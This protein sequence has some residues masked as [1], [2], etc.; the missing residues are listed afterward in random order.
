MKYINNGKDL[1]V[2]LEGR[3]DTN[4]AAETEKA[5]IAALE[6]YPESVPEFD[7]SS[8]EYISSAG[9]RVMMKM[10]RRFGTKLKAVNA[11]PE[12]YDI[13][14]VTGFTE[15]MNVE[16]RLRE[17]SVDGCEVIGTGFYGTVYRIDPETIVKV[18]Q[19]PECLPI[20]QNERKLAKLAFVKGVPTAISYDI[21][22]VGDSYGTVFELLNAQ[23]FN[24][25]L[26][27]EPENFDD[28]M[29]KYVDFLKVV[30][31]AEMDPGTLPFARDVFLRYADELR[32]CL[33]D[34]QC[35]RLKELFGALPD[36]LHMVHGDYQM[37]NVMMV[38]DEPMLIDMDTLS[39]GQ[40]IFDL[41]ALYVTYVAF[42]ED[43]PDNFMNF[44]GI[45][46]EL[47]KRIWQGILENYFDTKDK[48][49]LADINDKIQLIASMRFLYILNG[50]D[51]RNSD[52]GA[53]RIK[54]SQEH[55]TELLGRVDS[56]EINV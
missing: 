15:L 50:S 11:S 54:H 29:R 2:Y 27:S 24:D 22:K 9:L 32:G 25:M 35:A 30:H 10:C 31:S 42:P 1:T 36:D 56:L 21:V 13:F 38:G 40:P 53:L 7:L 41:Q 12:V 34:D 39:V 49:L 45:P 28:I 43:D 19:S 5:I 52:L 48:A 47:G 16:K 44:L 20:I 26:R 23:S 3:I 8:L 17:L 18:Y 33:T 55:I 6:E 46:D 37:K 14:E 4:N 51:L